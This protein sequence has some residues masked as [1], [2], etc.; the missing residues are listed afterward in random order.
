MDGFIEDRADIRPTEVAILLEFLHEKGL[1]FALSTPLRSAHMIRGEESGVPVQPA[2]Q[3]NI[4]RQS[5]GLAGE[6]DED[7]LGDILRGGGVA[8][9]LAERGGMHE[10]DVAP[11]EFGKGRLVPPADVGPE[12]F[13]ILGWRVHFRG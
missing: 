8:T 9:Q 2:R 13:S 7:G 6:I 5:R 3:D 11:D 4:G 10:V 12:Q 1:G